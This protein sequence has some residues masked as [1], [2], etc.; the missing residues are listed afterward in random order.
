M[1]GPIDS[2]GAISADGFASSAQT[3]K[4]LWGFAIRET[5]GAAASV[6]FRDGGNG[7]KLLAPRQVLAANGQVLPQTFNVGIGTANG[8]WVHV[9]SG[10]V[11]VIVYGS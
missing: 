10:T 9:V 4:E 7:G 11:E 8:V 5:A 3:F 2:S 6:E 1:R